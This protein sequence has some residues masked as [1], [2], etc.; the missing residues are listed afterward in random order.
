[1][2]TSTALA[3]NIRL[4]P[5]HQLFHNLVFWQATWFL[6]FQDILS[7]SQAILLYVIYDLT[8]TVFEVPSGYMSD[9]VGRRIT[10]VASAGIY[11]IG[12]GLLPVGSSFAV[13]ALAQGMI[14]VAA[15][16]KSGTDTAFLYQSLNGL[17]RAG[18]ME[19]QSL[20]AWRFGFVGLG[21]S[22]A[23]GGGLALWAPSLPFWLSALSLAVATYCALRFAEPPSDTSD[24]TSEWSRMRALFARFSQPIVAWLFCLGLL[25]YGFSHIPFVFGQP[26]IAE[27]L[28][29][30]G[31]QVEAPAVSGIVTA[32][33]MGLSV[34][35]SLA[36][37]GL[38][39]RLGLV[40]LLLIAF[41]IQVG[42]AVALAAFGSVFAIALLL[43]R[44]VPDSL[45]TPFIQ[46]H[47]QPL[48]GDESRATF[49]SVKSLAGRLLFAASLALAAGS[50]S[51]LG[52][53]PL[54]DL[55]AIL[56]VY[57]VVGSIALIGLAL[58]ARS[59]GSTPDQS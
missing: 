9:R 14:G 5:W 32:L 48:L 3:R 58:W 31:Y 19:R 28:A 45:S 30:I 46:A 51:A 12:L 42:L 6:Y 37:P 44:M 49:L 56:W 8:V 47:L 26:F 13:L 52:Q 33:M 35:V 43:L 2:S 25:M 39:K 21:L 16:F 15:A 4:Y 11:T 50:T 27:T 10:L 1:M 41:G 40:T 18:E 17:G 54:G 36:A 55:Q 24:A 7:A 34:L 20:R 38:R 53:M 29:A 22:A 59:I 23:I 57:G